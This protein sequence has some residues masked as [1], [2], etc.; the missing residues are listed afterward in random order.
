MRLT[1]RSQLRRLPNRGSYEPE[2][3]NSILDAA[4]LAHVGFQANGLGRTGTKA[5]VSKR[6]A[7]LN[8]GARGGQS[9]CYRPTRK[10]KMALP[11]VTI[12]DR[13]RRRG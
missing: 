3:I 8:L 2:I 11:A 10:K 4:F 6:K 13:M 9:V 1:K 5:G 7:A 12:E